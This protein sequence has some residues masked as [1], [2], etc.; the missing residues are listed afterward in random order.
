MQSIL[1]G[2]V[3]V[4]MDLTDRSTANPAREVAKRFGVRSIPD[5]RVLAADGKELAVIDSADV[6]DLI[7]QLTPHARP[8]AQ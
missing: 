3:L 8:S 2:F 1:G 5:M 4:K 6:N 7:A